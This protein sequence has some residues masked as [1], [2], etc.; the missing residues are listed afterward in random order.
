[1]ENHPDE[2]SFF[3]HT[4]V[5]LAG[6]VAADY[7]KRVQNKQAYLHNQHCVPLAI[8]IVDNTVVI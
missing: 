2:E 7:V 3:S 8:N 1:M 4:I 5:K 6:L